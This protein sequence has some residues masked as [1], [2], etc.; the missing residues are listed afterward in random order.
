MS[1][2][3]EPV[4]RWDLASSSISSET[5]ESLSRGNIHRDVISDE[6]NGIAQDPHFQEHLGDPCSNHQTRDISTSIFSISSEEEERL[7]RRNIH[8]DI[9]SAELTGTDQDSHFQEHLNDLCLDHG[10]NR[11][12]EGNRSKWMNR[13][14]A[15]PDKDSCQQDSV[16]EKSMAS[17]VEVSFEESLDTS[18]S[19]DSM[20]VEREG[21]QS[22]VKKW[23]QS[24]FM[25]FIKRSLNHSPKSRRQIEEEKVN[26]FINGQPIPDS[27][28]KQAEM[29]A[30]PIQPGDYWY[31]FQAGFWGVMGHACI[32]IIPPH[33]EEFHFP[34][35]ANCA[36]GNTGVFVNGRELHKEDLN[37]LASR[38]LP[39][40]RDKLYII[41]ISGRVLDEDSEE[42]I[43]NLGKLAPT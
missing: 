2:L 14:K 1:N 32:G 20:E 41:E 36:G 23:R 34:L 18:L 13:A 28:V 3:G 8:G 40:T 19:Q 5:E 12:R 11:Y 30:G 24:L 38:G 15:K 21:D 29:R 10:A 25:G 27:M 39:T 22:T 26:V 42:E 31:D 43:Y 37:L 4:K 9:S 33:I 6:L 7:S 17:E 16:K 35:P